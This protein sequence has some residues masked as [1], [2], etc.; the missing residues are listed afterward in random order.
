MAMTRTDPITTEII[1]NYLETVSQEMSATVERTA[2]SPIFTLTH[3]YSCGVFFWDGREVSLL[4]RDLAVPVHIFAAL[5]SVTTMFERFGG[6]IADGDVFLVT[7]PYLG[8]SHCPDWTIIKPIMVDGGRAAFLPS[9][10]GHVID[11]GGPV[12]GN[13]NPDAREVWHEGFRIPP[14]RIVDQGQPVPDLWEVILANTRLR[15]AVHGDLNAMVGACTVGQRRITELLGKYGPAALED[16]VE[17]ILNHSESQLRDQIAS[18]PNGTYEYTEYIDHDFAGNE[19]IPVRVTVTVRDDSL[20]LDFAGTSPQVPGFI[21][22]PRGNSLSQVFTAISPLCPEIPIN[23]GFFRPVE[24]DLPAG[25]L[26]NPNPPAPVGHCTLCPGT[27]VIDAVM[28]AF[29]PVVPERVATASCDMHSARCFGINSQTG[30][31]WVAP[32]MSATPMSAGGAFGTDGWGAW[33]ATFSALKTPP[34]EMYEAQYPY[35]Y[36][37]SEY[38]T[39]TAAPGRWRGAPAYHYRRRNTD[40]MR[41]SVYNSGYQYPLTG[42]RGG[43]KG[44]GNYWVLREGRPD[45]LSVTTSCY[46]EVLPAGTTVFHQSGAGGGWGSPFDRDPELVLS[47][48]LDELV[49]LDGAQRDYGVVIDPTTRC[50]DVE[51]TKNLRKEIRTAHG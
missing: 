2:I 45:E 33:A 15:E 5:D 12:P 18:W 31:Y 28:K 21:N 24:V 49:S 48:W 44:A 8:G 7:D 41:C 40:E 29:E 35:L 42:Y 37:L 10:R 17:Y 3:D 11:V 6:Q 22:S 30:R 16:S 39:D 43:G 23:S 14:L 19:D 25:S 51:A 38:A 4:A 46:M 50:V 27:T 32:D 34:Q 9:V 36:L 20:H 13:Y 26:V 1:R 47:D